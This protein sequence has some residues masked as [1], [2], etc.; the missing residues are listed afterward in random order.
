MAVANQTVAD[1]YRSFYGL[2]DDYH[3]IGVATNGE[4]WVMVGSE[5]LGCQPSRLG[6]E[7]CELTS[8]TG[9]ASLPHSGGASPTPSPPGSGDGDVEAAPLG[10]IR[11]AGSHRLRRKLKLTFVLRREAELDLSSSL[12]I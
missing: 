10:L 11:V 5:A 9:D 2:S 6:N 8:D 1:A 12:I 7:R 4:D 3:A